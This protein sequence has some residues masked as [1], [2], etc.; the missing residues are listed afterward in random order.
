MLRSTC[1]KPK[2]WAVV[3][4]LVAFLVAAIGLYGLC[5][6]STPLPDA[7]QVLVV[8]TGTQPDSIDPALAKDAPTWHIVRPTYE[9][10]LRYR[11]GTTEIEPCLAQSWDVSLDGLNYTFH[12][13]PGVLFH[14]G[15]PLTADAVK[16]SYDR[17]I[18]IGLGPAVLFKSVTSVDVLDGE[19][20]TFHLANP[21][22]DFLYGLTQLMIVSPAAVKAHEQNGDLARQWLSDH[23]AGTGPYKLE[24]WQKG[25]V[26][27]LVRDDNYWTPWTGAHLRKVLFRFVPEAATQKLLLLRGEV[28]YADFLSADDANELKQNQAFTVYAEPTLSEIY[29]AMN[30]NSG[31]TADVNLRKAIA[32]A[33]DYATY[34][35]QIMKGWAFPPNGPLPTGYSDNLSGVPRFGRDMQRA[36]DFLS[37]S[38]FAGEQ[39]NLTFVYV[40]GYERYRQLG[41]LLKSNLSELGINVELSPQPWATLTKMSTTPDMRP[42]LLEYGYS[43]PVPSPFSYLYSMYHSGTGHWAQFGYQNADVD[44]LLDEAQSMTDLSARA[45]VLRQVQCLLISDMPQVFVE[46]RTQWYIFSSQVKGYDFDPAWYL[47]PNWWDMYLVAK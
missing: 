22:L 43:A 1:C 25:Q 8:A 4:A 9:G 28:Q 36:R 13:N 35:S 34:S 19:T 14:D 15:A 7:Q 44:R 24:S 11:T 31:P 46:E 45:D 47:W 23:E 42:D 26:I 33:F 21:D 40:S 27:T 18:T 20:V 38:M 39:V 10:L 16:E 30:T 17:L 12:L 3:V 6:D 37:K 32:F 5:A 41:E 29:I 2:G